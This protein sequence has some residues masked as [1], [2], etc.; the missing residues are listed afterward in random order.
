MPSPRLLLL[1][2]LLALLLQRLPSGLYTQSP[3]LRGFQVELATLVG[4]GRGTIEDALDGKGQPGNST[5]MDAVEA[6][7]FGSPTLLVSGLTAGGPGGEGGPVGAL[8]GNRES[9]RAVLGC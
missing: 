7:V 3:P 2:L 5:T 6:G 1:T 4:K 9:E 8:S